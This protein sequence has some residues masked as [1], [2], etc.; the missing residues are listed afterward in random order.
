MVFAPKFDLQEVVVK[1]L[2]WKQCVALIGISFVAIVVQVAIYSEIHGETKIASGTYGIVEI[3][4]AELPGSGD[5]VQVQ[6]KIE[7]NGT[8]Y[9]ISDPAVVASYIKNP[10]PLSCDVLELNKV[11]CQPRPGPPQ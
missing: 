7:E 11:V 10:G 3:N 8:R 9:S 4:S 2:N 1:F 6:L 5:F